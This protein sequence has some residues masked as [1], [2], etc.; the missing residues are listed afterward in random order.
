[1][2]RNA[3]RALVFLFVAR[4]A[5]AAPAADTTPA[6]PLS[7]ISA[8]SA[9]S[10]ARSAVLAYLALWSADALP[11]AAAPFTEDLVLTYS[12]AIREVEAEVRGRTSVV[13]QV[14]AVAHLGRQW[15]FGEVRLFPTLRS[16]VYFVQYTA[17]ATSPIGRADHRR[18]RGDP[19]SGF[20]EAERRRDVLRLADGLRPMRHY[21][22]RLVEQ[23]AMA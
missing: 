9:E 12:H 19:K 11:D 22:Q 2:K 6:E 17:S 8:P 15:K 20:D 10:T 7:R 16:S 21:R 1:M 18:H 3:L 14:R 13:N 4:L 5:T 23:D